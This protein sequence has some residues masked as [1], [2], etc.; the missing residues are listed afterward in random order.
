VANSQAVKVAAKVV[1]PMANGEPNSTRKI[2]AKNPRRDPGVSPRRLPEGPAGAPWP[3]AGR[4]SGPA[5]SAAAVRSWSRVEA[6]D[7]SAMQQSWGW[8]G[9]N[10]SWSA[11]DYFAKYTKR[12]LGMPS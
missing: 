6:C 3:A 2:D 7:E 12:P 8:G 11:D 5:E 9:R 1:M 4:G 10:T